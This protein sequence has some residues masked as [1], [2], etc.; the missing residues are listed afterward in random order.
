[1]ELSKADKKVARILVEKGLMAEL[2]NGLHKA[3]KILQDWKSGKLDNKAAYQTLFKHLERFDEGIEQRYDNTPNNMILFVVVGL[4][5]EGLIEA[6]ELEA[7]SEDGKLWLE[8]I[9]RLGR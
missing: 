2:A 7:F 6:Q 8:R 4:L 5:N 9:L 1:M 3:D